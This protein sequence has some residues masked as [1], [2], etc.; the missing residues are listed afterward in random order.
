VKHTFESSNSSQALVLIRSVKPIHVN[1]ALLQ[2]AVWEWSHMYKHA[3]YLTLLAHPFEFMVSL[4][5][6][7]SLTVCQLHLLSFL[8]LQRT[9]NGFYSI[10]QRIIE[11]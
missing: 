1:V 8:F 2:A 5:H 9:V 6:P 10:S 7:V 3:A 11:M 4:V